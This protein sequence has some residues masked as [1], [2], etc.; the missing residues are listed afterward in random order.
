MHQAILTIPTRGRGLVDITQEVREIVAESG[1]HSGLA[2]L[3]ILHT[4]ASLTVQE[5]ADPRVRD[6][7]DAWF[8]QQVRDGDPLFT[9]VEEGP[10]DMSAHVRASLTDT[11]LTVPVRHGALLLGTWQ[12]IYLFEHRTQAHRRRVAVTIQG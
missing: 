9:H 10:D 5:N 11:S 7:L 2:H 8:S 4:S 1:T 6:D 3:F 12:A